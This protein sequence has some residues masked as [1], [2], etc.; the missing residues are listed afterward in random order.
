M[1]SATRSM[2]PGQIRPLTP[3]V[4]SR[5]EPSCPLQEPPC[6]KEQRLRR[7]PKALTAQRRLQKQ[8][9]DDT[10][11]RASAGDQ[12]L[13]CRPPSGCR[14]DRQP[15]IGDEED[16]RH[17]APQDYRGYDPGTGIR[18]FRACHLH[19]HSKG[20]SRETKTT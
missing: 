2:S 13:R 20:T 19:H 17:H 3:W 18:T 15:C 9:E 4:R 10:Y 5:C 8:A 16:Q 1:R 14:A 12:R 7:G 11:D 6:P